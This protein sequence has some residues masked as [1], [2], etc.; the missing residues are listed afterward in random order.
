M[1]TAITLSRMMLRWV[2]QQPWAR[3]AHLF[4][5]TEEEFSR[6]RPR[7]DRERGAAPCLTSSA[8]AS[9]GYV[10]SA[11]LTIPG[12]IF[13][14]PDVH[15][16]RRL[17]LQ[18]S[19]AYTGGTIWEVHF[20]DGT[21]DPADGARRPRG[22]GP[23][24]SRSP[25]PRSDGRDYVL[26]RTEA[27]ALRETDGRRGLGRRRLASASPAA[28]ERRARRVRGAG[29]RGQR[30]PRPATRQPPPRPAVAASAAP[31]PATPRLV[32]V[33]G[34]VPAAVA[35]RRRRRPVDRRPHRGRVRRAGDRA[36]GARSG[37]STRCASRTP[38]APS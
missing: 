12:L 19:I 32:A 33:A 21:P 15:P 13:I 2:V 29:R 25:S 5:V 6:G 35:R 8:S 37:P 11:V 7:P 26:I 16:R 38:S 36:P 31:A 27:L 34:R 3:Q 18:F 17:G 10:F 23:G 4:G 14:L 20:E 9:Y 30:R 1:F 28:A 24:R 22:A